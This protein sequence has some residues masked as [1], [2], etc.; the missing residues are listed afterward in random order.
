[1][2]RL[3]TVILAALLI[4][5]ITGCAAEA[6]PEGPPGPPGPQGLP[7]PTGPAGV[8]GAPGPAGAD[9]LSFEPPIYVGSEACAECHEDLY[10]VFAQSGHNWQLNAVVDGEVPDYPFT[11]LDGP[12][13]GYTWDDIAYVVGG[14]NWKARFIDRE[15]Y[16]ITG[17]D[18]TAVTQYNLPNNALDVDDQWVSYHAGEANLSYDCGTCHTTAYVPSG[19]QNG[20]PG[21]VGTWALDGIQCEECHGPGS[22]HA[23]H[24]LSFNMVVDRDAQS[25]NACHARGSMDA[26][27]ASDGFIQH[28]DSYETLF[29]G[30]HAVMDCVTCH[31][32]HA[33]VV[34]L[35]QANAPTVQTTC[36]SCHYDQDQV[37]SVAIHARI[38]VDCVD[39]H[40]PRLIQVA[41]GNV[42][43]HAADMRTHLVAIDPAQISQFNEDGTVIPQ[44][45]LDYACRSCH[46]ADGFAPELPDDA[47]IEAATGYHAPQVEEA[48]PTAE[49]EVTP[50]AETTGGEGG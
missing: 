47:L 18:E 3:N 27:S 4:I 10:E 30:K 32:P 12:P 21:L 6:G 41:A 26:V 40:M 9:G 44:V 7:G 14:Y 37:H 13:A 1:M 15:G 31:D 38:G 33:G 46:Y 29:Q 43:Q 42:D 50:E 25:C 34:Q 2:R 28:H 20:L 36:E 45:S 17:A 24:P 19:N 5:A 22:A 8:A 35:R 11:N 39:C 49:P 48:V 23:S 16:L